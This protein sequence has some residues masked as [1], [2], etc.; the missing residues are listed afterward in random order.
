MFFFAEKR[1]SY[2]VFGLK[3]ASFFFPTFGRKSAAFC[4]FWGIFCCFFSFGIW[5]PWLLVLFVRCFRYIIFP[6]QVDRQTWKFLCMCMMNVRTSKQNFTSICWLIQVLRTKNDR[7]ATTHLSHIPPNVRA[8]LMNRR[9]RSTE[10][11]LQGV[12][13]HRAHTQKF[14]GLSVDLFW[15]YNVSKTSHEQH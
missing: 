2:S 8:Y 1:C 7:S 10:I 5:S 9:K 13:V 6:E 12:C 14:S 11:L 4:C 15:K 3:N